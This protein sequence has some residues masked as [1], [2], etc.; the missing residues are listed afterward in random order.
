[1]C[2]RRYCRITASAASDELCALLEIVDY[3]LNENGVTGHTEAVLIEAK[4]R[5]TEDSPIKTMIQKVQDAEEKEQAF[6]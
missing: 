6:K 5:N 1:M 4:K 2:D 3:M